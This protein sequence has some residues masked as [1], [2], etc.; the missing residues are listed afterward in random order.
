META[1]MRG[2]LAGLQGSLCTAAFPVIKNKKHFMPSTALS[3][4]T[5]NQSSSD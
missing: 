2:I 4:M 3:F 1:P 5:I